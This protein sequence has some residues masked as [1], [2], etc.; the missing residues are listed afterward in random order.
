MGSTKNSIVNINDT[1]YASLTSDGFQWGLVGSYINIPNTDISYSSYQYHTG[2]EGSVGIDHTWI[3]FGRYNPYNNTNSSPDLAGFFDT[4]KIDNNYGIGISMD[5]SSTTNVVNQ[6]AP[7]I[8]TTSDGITKNKMQYLQNVAFNNS[9]SNDISMDATNHCNIGIIDNYMLS[10]SYLQLT[11]FSGLTCISKLSKYDPIKTQL[12]YDKKNNTLH[13]ISLVSVTFDIVSVYSIDFKLNTATDKSITTDPI[14]I[15]VDY[16]FKINDI[17]IEKKPYSIDI[18]NNNINIIKDKEIYSKFAANRISYSCKCSLGYKVPKTDNTL[19]NI[20]GSLLF[21]DKLHEYFY[22]YKPKCVN[23][24]ISFSTFLNND[25]FVSIIYNT[26][27]SSMYFYY[28]LETGTAHAIDWISGTVANAT[29]FW[30]PETRVPRTRTLTANKALSTSDTWTINSSGTINSS[31]GSAF[32]IY[33][34]NKVTSLSYTAIDSTHYVSL[35]IYTN[36]VIINLCVDDLNHTYTFTNNSN[37]IDVGEINAMSVKYTSNSIPIYIVYFTYK[38]WHWAYTFISGDK[39]DNIYNIT[40]DIVL[41]TDNGYTQYNKFLTGFRNDNPISSEYLVEYGYNGR[42]SDKSIYNDYYIYNININ[43]ILPTMTFKQDSSGKD[44]KYY[45][46]IY[47]NSKLI[48]DNIESQY[49]NN[50]SDWYLYATNI[51]DISILNMSRI[52]NNTIQFELDLSIIS[53]QN[54][55]I[56][57]SIKLYLFYRSDVHLPLIISCDMNLDLRLLRLPNVTFNYI[58]NNNESTNYTL[59]TNESKNVIHLNH[60]NIQNDGFKF[61]CSDSMVTN[62]KKI[63]LELC[64]DY[65]NWIDRYS[66]STHTKITQTIKKTNIKLDTYYSFNDLLSGDNNII[67]EV[68]FLL[69]GDS[70]DSVSQHNKNNTGTIKGMKIIF[71]STI[72]YTQTNYCPII[73]YHAYH[74]FI[75]G[76]IYDD[77]I[78]DIDSTINQ[79]YNKQVISNYNFLPPIDSTETYIPTFNFRC[80]PDYLDDKNKYSLNYENSSTGSLST[81]LST[82]L[83]SK[84][85]LVGIPSNIVSENN[86]YLTTDDG[87]GYITLYNGNIF[88][89]ISEKY[90]NYILKPNFLF[91]YISK[92]DLGVAGYNTGL[93]YASG[94]LSTPSGYLDFH[95][96]KF[97][98]TFN[99]GSLSNGVIP[100]GK[101]SIFFLVEDTV[102]NR[103]GIDLIGY[104]SQ[105]GVFPTSGD[106]NTSSF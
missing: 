104:A 26:D 63:D 44:T 74:N 40:K 90:N 13:Y 73:T 17:S 48:I 62:I 18:L 91:E 68:P 54:Y 98:N 28:G 24:I 46:N 58:N 20:T 93:V 88:N 33:S 96:I 71:T 67:Y 103:T 106:F 4:T 60:D 70:N 57:L 105:T 19:Y 29:S 81:R 78:I 100:D 50:H 47:H 23:N 86:E 55:D 36:N 3:T 22:I 11:L 14:N 7:Y 49:N 97:T 56:I 31:D 43:D 85:W 41:V 35:C 94:L 8:C 92:V 95:N 66:P 42:R 39:I 77:N 21:A 16:K 84:W 52:N 99:K 69:S 15:L 87:L 76:K 5:F 61:V 10:T 1:I 80:A 34:N 72:G 101:Y 32:P 89:G 83:I 2:S 6:H 27:I 102:G 9:L 65:S 79:D 25:G 38:T 30:V 82:P 51:D 37:G 53:K 59:A 75:I 12:V 64:I 45:I